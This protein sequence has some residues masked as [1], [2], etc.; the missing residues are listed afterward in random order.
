[1]MWRMAD[2]ESDVEVARPEC[3][4]CGQVLEFLGTKN[5]HEGS[6]GW[7]FFLGDLGELFTNRERLDVYAC[8][9]CGKVEFF[10]DGVGEA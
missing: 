4:L 6:R 5:I 8:P 1:M 2:V 9:D 3:L 10:L 7:G